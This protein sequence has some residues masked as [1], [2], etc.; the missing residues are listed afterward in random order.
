MRYLLD[1]SVI[2]NH[3]RG[4][5]SIKI[6]FLENGSAVSIITQAELFYGAYKSSNSLTNLK[7]LKAMFLDLGIE[8]IT[9]TKE[10]IEQYAKIKANLEKQGKKLDEF[11]FLIAA[12]AIE[13]NLILVSDNLSHF[14][15]ISSLKV[16]DY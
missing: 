2:V 8:I 1:T 12:T 10:I 15:R 14:K 4:K 13:R 3:L 16:V 5:K 11:D 6:D 7:K 9:L